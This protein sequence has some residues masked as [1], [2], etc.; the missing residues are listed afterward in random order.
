MKLKETLAAIALMAAVSAGTTPAVAVESADPIKIAINE[1]TGQHLSAHIAAELLRKMGYNV[2]LVTAGGLPQFTAIARGE[3]HANPEVW[4]NSVTDIYTKGLASG[5]LVDLG[6]LG[7]E[8]QDGWIYPPYMEEKCPGLPS[9]KAL[10]DCAQAFATA[11][12]FPN[13]RLIAYPADWGTRSQ[14]LVAAIGLPFNPVPGGSEGAMIAELKGALAS[15]EPIL[16]MMWQPHSIFAEVDVKWV[17]WNPTG[18]E[19]VEE[20]QDRDTACGFEQAS[21]NKIVSRV[22]PEKWPGAASFLKA[23]TLTN[24]EQNHMIFEVDQRGRTI[25]DLVQEW[26]ADNEGKWSAWIAQ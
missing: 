7:L 15:G 13:G 14:D 23:Y 9:Y 2:E 24:E 12:T 26:I 5:D 1:W 18:G 22:L 16:M 3:L 21:V 10:F 8:P 11:E 17:E 6:E 19:C 20:E 4:D 25:E